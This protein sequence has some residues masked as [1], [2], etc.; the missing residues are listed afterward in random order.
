MRNRLFASARDGSAISSR[1]L[2][3]SR[4]VLA[5]GAV[6][7]LMALWGAGLAASVE[8]AAAP[9]AQLAVS[10]PRSSNAA[11]AGQTK[12]T[13]S[14][15]PSQT[16]G[17]LTAPDF[18][19]EAWA[20]DAAERR[21]QRDVASAFETR[22]VE[23]TAKKG[24]MTGEQFAA[25]VKANQLA[26]QAKATQL[27][28]ADSV[29]P[30]APAVVQLASLEMPGRPS[31]DASSDHETEARDVTVGTPVMAALEPDLPDL[32]L[33][34]SWR[35]AIA[36]KEVIAPKAVV[37][38]KEIIA[39]KDAESR[40]TPVA[41]LAYARPDNP[42]ERPAAKSAGIPWPGKTRRTAI[43]DITAGVVYMP[44]GEQLEAH[45]GRGAMRD[46][47]R[48]THVKMRGSTPPSTYKLSMREALFHGVEALR[49]TPV[50]GIAP[51]GRVGLLA[52]T[53]LLRVPGDSS[54]CIVF[55]N[56]PR[57]LAAF[58]RGEIDHVVV[59][60]KLEDTPAPRIASLFSNRG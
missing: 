9:D 32:G 14:A 52:H 57:F 34:P 49:L 17:T 23:P 56:Y 41:V 7:G 48:Y 20:R 4:S 46:N 21:H 11:F 25:L 47:P 6:L 51:Q 10:Q 37:A 13:K 54:G 3:G 22:F 58:K 27:A 36:R 53:Y 33:V 55:K 43:Y 2:A 35:P 31:L 38:P 50:N 26:A 1:R 39:P 45:S 28:Q 5:G 19:R 15:R 30:A 16:G 29:A 42:I 8:W 40:K 12:S 18:V 59:V 24:A 60:P 44:N